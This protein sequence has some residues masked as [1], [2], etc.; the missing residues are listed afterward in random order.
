MRQD[1][2]HDDTQ[3]T[4][5]KSQ[6]SNGGIRLSI[7]YSVSNETNSDWILKILGW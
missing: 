7:N 6:L 3:E 4:I 2:Q 5:L 1:T